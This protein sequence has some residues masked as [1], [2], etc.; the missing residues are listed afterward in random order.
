MNEA[1]CHIIFCYFSDT[2]CIVFV[3]MFLAQDDGQP[4]SLD[5]TVSVLLLSGQIVTLLWGECVCNCDCVM[6]ATGGSTALSF[7][8]R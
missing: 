7:L 3:N 1:H 2:V 8:G 4:F 6:L 5:H